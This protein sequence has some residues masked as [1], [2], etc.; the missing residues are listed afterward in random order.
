MSQMVTLLFIK[1]L[2]SPPLKQIRGGY[3]SLLI[4]ELHPF[5][6]CLGEGGGGRVQKNKKWKNSTLETISFIK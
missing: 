6:Y 3:K 5:P 2:P 1:P 4:K